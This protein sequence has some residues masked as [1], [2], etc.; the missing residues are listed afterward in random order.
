[1]WVKTIKRERH[2]QDS[3]H[4]DSIISIEYSDGFGRLLQT[5]T[6]AED[7]IFGATETKRILGDSGLPESQSASNGNAV[8][9]ERISTSH[10]NV[11]VSGWQVYNNKGKVVEKY[12]P[13]FDT[14]FDFKLN[15]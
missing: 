1:M 8:G 13:F 10:L 3:T 5:R 6:Q 7:I 4:D 9:S 2:F 14:G 12:E 15:D 11:V